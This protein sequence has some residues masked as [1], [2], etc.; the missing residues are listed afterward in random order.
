MTAQWPKTSMLHHDGVHPICS[1][2]MPLEVVKLS[3]I[4]MQE[5][6]VAA[7]WRGG[8]AVATAS[9]ER[10]RGKH[11]RGGSTYFQIE[12]CIIDVEIALDSQ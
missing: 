11:R 5:Q 3:H 6:I 12:M 1:Q 4:V 9:T 7:G 2:R 8:L 10:V